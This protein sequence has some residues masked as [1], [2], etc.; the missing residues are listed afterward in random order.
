MPRQQFHQVL[1][2]CGM[3]GALANDLVKSHAARY[4]R[5]DL[6]M[7]DTRDKILD[8]AERLF[9]SKGVNVVSLR[10][11]N[12][13]AGVS[14]GVLHYHFGG[15][16]GLLKAL[17]ER[18]LPALAVERQAM[19]QVLRDSKKAPV[20]PQLVEVIVVP[21]ARLAIDSGKG[22]RRFI[23]LVAHLHL[24]QNRIYQIEAARYSAAIDPQLAQWLAAQL[25]QTPVEI[26]ELRLSMALH[27]MYNTLAEIGEPSRVWF[28]H[29]EAHAP[30]PWTVVETLTEFI[31]KAVR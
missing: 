12:T 25:P 5:L 18:R 16:D 6:T 4:L 17:L 9:S 8:T 20:L 24:E 27:A 2:L 3:I 7:Q 11:I 22:G 1:K 29:L 14:Q 13:A 23:K 21:L 28:P 15:R 31:A 30:E 26:I 10:D 19:L